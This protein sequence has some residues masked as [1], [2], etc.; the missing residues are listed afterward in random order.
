MAG[1]LMKYYEQQILNLTEDARN[2]LARQCIRTL[3]STVLSNTDTETIIGS[4]LIGAKLGIGRDRSL[5]RGERNFSKYIATIIV[6][7]HSEET[8]TSYI[9]SL[10]LNE[11][12]YDV[13]RSFST[14]GLEPAMAFF[15]YALCWALADGVM[16]PDAEQRLESIFGMNL[17]VDFGNSGLESIPA[18]RIRVSG[19]E[20]EIAGALK[21]DSE[22]CFLRDIQAHFPNR[23][24]GEVKRALDRLCEE[25]VLSRVETFAGAMY[26][27]ENA[28]SIETA[29]PDSGSVC[30]RV[31][32]KKT[33]KTDENTRAAE[34]AKAKEAAEKKTAR[35]KEC[36]QRYT[37]WQE[38]CR[39]ITK[40]REEMVERLCREEK[41]KYIRDTEAD[42]KRRADLSCGKI[43]ALEQRRAA[44]EATASSLGFFQFQAKQEQRALVKQIDKELA[45]ERESLTLAEKQYRDTLA[46]AD[47]VVKKKRS[48][49][50]ARAEKEC[51]LPREPQDGLLAIEDE[52]VCWMT[53][54]RLYQVA[55]FMQLLPGFST[56]QISAM[57]RK[58]ADSYRVL[59]VED[60]RKTYYKVNL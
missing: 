49:F 9:E 6:Q 4:L 5:N 40:Q 50:K 27:L 2:E 25:G 26:V 16:E 47:E 19:L 58:M 23:S 8:L 41:E 35:I 34:A 22:L 12:M 15:R 7:D 55:E 54:G 43:A 38:E 3:L 28:D 56:T 1:N 37:R 53:P 13:A 32:A 10:T 21:A 59:R 31:E 39:T 20:A 46:R 18:P 11:S 45:Q 51:V 48:A 24:E 60:K 42:Y 17:I 52:I 57:L 36:C 29:Y 14:D 44:A 33:H 30:R